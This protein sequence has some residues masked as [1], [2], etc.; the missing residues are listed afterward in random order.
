MVGLVN[1]AGP[2]VLGV[3]KVTYP[4]PIK[5]IPSGIKRLEGPFAPESSPSQI[6]IADTRQFRR[7]PV[8][9]PYKGHNLDV[10]A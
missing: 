4:N 2:P 8:L 3:F 5:E 9:H 6:I 1:P 7:W 10:L